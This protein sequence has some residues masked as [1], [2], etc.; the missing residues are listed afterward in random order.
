MSKID[1]LSELEIKKKYILRQINTNYRV[2]ETRANLF[3]Q[4]NV[5]NEEIKKEKFKINFLRRK[6]DKNNNPNKP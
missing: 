1:R 6:N 2:S 5:I 3:T 4:L